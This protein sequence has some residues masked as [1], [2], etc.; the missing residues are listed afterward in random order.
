MQEIL[1][2]QIMNQNQGIVV[3]D[4]KSLEHL[5]DHEVQML[6]HQPKN[7]DEVLLKIN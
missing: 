3:A 6:V 2:P 7:N 4:C 5:S 1:D